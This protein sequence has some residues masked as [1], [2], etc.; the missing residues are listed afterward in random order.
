MAASSTSTG[1]LVLIGMF[2]SFT[3]LLMLSPQEEAILTSSLAHAL[4]QHS[5]T[6]G[7]RLVNLPAAEIAKR[8]ERLK[9]KHGL[10]SALEPGILEFEARKDWVRLG[11]TSYFWVKEVRAELR[12]QG[13]RRE[14]MS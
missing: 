13:L 3:L 7:E 8:C 11:C 6:I 12:G 9:A 2:I 4:G 1:S 14:A 5:T 10:A